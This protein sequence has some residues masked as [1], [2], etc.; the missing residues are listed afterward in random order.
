VRK[1]IKWPYF[2]SWFSVSSYEY[3]RLILE[4]FTSNLVYS[5]IWLNLPRD[6]LYLGYI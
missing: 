3:R 2:Y 1:M 5:Q 4:N 6:D